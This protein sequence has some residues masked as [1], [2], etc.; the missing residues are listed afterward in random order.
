M[1]KKRLVSILFIALSISAF[2]ETLN[3]NKLLPDL[4]EEEMQKVIKLGINLNTIDSNNSSLASYIITEVCLIYHDLPNYNEKVILANKYLANKISKEVISD[5]AFYY[6]LACEKKDMLELIIAA[7]VDLNK[8]KYPESAPSDLPPIGVAYYYNNINGAQLL[9][10]NGA[11]DIKTEEKVNLI[12]NGTAMDY[13]IATARIMIEQNASVNWKNNYSGSCYFRY[14][15]TNFWM[16]KSLEYLEFLIENGM[17]INNLGRNRIEMEPKYDTTPLSYLIIK[18]RDL[19]NKVIIT[20]TI[21]A[22]NK[23]LVNGAF[24]S[25]IDVEKKTPLHYAAMYNEF[26]V[27]KELIKANAKIMARDIHNKTPLDYAQD[28]KIIK[29]LKDIGA[30]E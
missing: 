12:L 7:G 4:S 30:E 1:K 16:D 14:I 23:L 21:L 22:I 13:D 8:W 15:S 25:G 28:G 27:A 18:V 24:V 10:K 19:N 26:E 11:V 20:S 5:D 29:L 9:V 17:I 3:F 6:S 2:S